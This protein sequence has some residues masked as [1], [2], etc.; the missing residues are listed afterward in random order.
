MSS[1]GLWP[2]VTSGIEQR[3]NVIVRHKPPLPSSYPTYPTTLTPTLNALPL[4]HMGRA[5][6]VWYYLAWR[7]QPF[8][9]MGL[10]ATYVAT[11]LRKQTH[12]RIGSLN[13]T[14]LMAIQDGRFNLRISFKV[15]C[16]MVY[17]ENLTRSHQILF[18]VSK[19]KYLQ[20]N[21]ILPESLVSICLQCIVGLPG[22][23]K[24]CKSNATNV[25]KTN[26]NKKSQSIDQ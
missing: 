22:D 18:S 5:P 17:H 6:L 20:R 21:M 19:W 2:A 10:L 13:S 14:N 15:T 1:C 24:D 26:Q 4:P 12:F 9:R 25:Q 7:L 3:L 8:W 23:Q 16:N 11:K